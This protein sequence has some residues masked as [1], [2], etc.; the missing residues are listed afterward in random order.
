MR[1]Y[2]LL[3]SVILFSFAGFSQ[4][5]IEIKNFSSAQK[6]EWDKFLEYWN[7]NGNGTCMPIME[8]Q[9]DTGKCTQFDFIAD[10]TIGNNG[11]ITKVK[12]IESKVLCENKIIQKDLL[13]CFTSALIDDWGT[14]FK[15]LK[16]RVV[17]NAKL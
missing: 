12:V 16:D 9:I 5:L 1:K 8:A 6:A 15:K 7:G 11:K 2:F 13:D 17:K 14:T 4:K 10:V 3:T